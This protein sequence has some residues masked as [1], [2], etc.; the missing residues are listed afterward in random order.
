MYPPPAAAEAVGS[1]YV[2]ALP[3]EI[4]LFKV[5]CV[6][7]MLVEGESSMDLYV[8][9][10]V[11]ALRWAPE[12]F[13]PVSSFCAGCGSSGQGPEECPEVLPVLAFSFWSN[14]LPLVFCQSV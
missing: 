1:V 10:Y 5:L 6:M 8:C 9:V 13:L 2:Q 12:A 11:R 14:C 3:A 4:C 7:F